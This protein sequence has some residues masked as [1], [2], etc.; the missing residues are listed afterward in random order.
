MV[1]LHNTESELC[2]RFP[3]PRSLCAHDLCGDRRSG[4]RDRY[5]RQMRERVQQERKDKE[6]ALDHL[7]AQVYARARPLQFLRHHPVPL[8][9]WRR[10]TLAS[11]RPV[12]KACSWPCGADTTLSSR[13]RSRTIGALL[14]A[15]RQLRSHG[16]AASHFQRAVVRPTGAEGAAPLRHTPAASGPVV[17]LHTYTL[18]DA[19][20]AG[21]CCCC[22]CCF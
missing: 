6:E 18:F 13:S 7:R 8:R 15:D 10:T 14:A 16:S 5:E 2:Q 1:K 22:C 20:P 12:K 4:W 11:W 3:F 19:W 21:C 17:F 9:S